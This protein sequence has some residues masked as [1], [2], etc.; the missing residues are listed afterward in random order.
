M[1]TVSEKFDLEQAIADAQTRLKSA[2]ESQDMEEA[3]KRQSRLKI[4]ILL[5]GP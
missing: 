3:A 1:Q 2:I 4:R 5:T